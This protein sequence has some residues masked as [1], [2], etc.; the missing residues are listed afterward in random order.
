[1]KKFFISSTFYDM[2]AERDMIQNIVQPA[3]NQKLNEQGEYVSFSDLRWG[4]DTISDTTKHKILDACFDEID[5]CK[6]YF[7]VFIGGRYG[8]IPNELATPYQDRFG[9][10]EILNKSITELEVLYALK[11]N[12]NN[13][14]R[15]LFYFKDDADYEDE[16]GLKREQV[17]ERIS[18]LRQKIENIAPTQIRHYNSIVDTQTEEILANQLVSDICNIVSGEKTL[19]WQ[20]R[21]ANQMKVKFDTSLPG[22]SSQWLNGLKNESIDLVVLLFPE[23]KV[24]ESLII[25]FASQIKSHKRTNL[26]N[27]LLGRGNKETNAIYVNVG[28]TKEISETHELQR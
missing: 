15:C 14:N 18:D 24:K 1:M 8:W 27:K 17:I 3:V 16:D 7:I 25:N 19:S 26:I 6:P 23:C 22:L 28:A 11:L 4:I 2:H 12:T 10:I 5:S 9:N 21:I 13:L 20:D